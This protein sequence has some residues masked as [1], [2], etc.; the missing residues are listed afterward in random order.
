MNDGISFAKS[1]LIEIIAE[2]R[3]FPVGTAMQTAQPTFAGDA[4]QLAMSFIRQ[5]GGSAFPRAEKLVPQGFPAMLHEVAWRF[6]NPDAPGT[7]LQIGSGIFTANALPPY[8]RWSAFRPTVQN[9]VNALLAARSDG[10][11]DQPFSGLSLCYMN[12]FLPELMEQHSQLEFMERIL[13]FKVKVP[14]A[15]KRVQTAGRTTG[16]S[17]NLSIPISGTTK[18]LILVVADGT[19]RPPGSTHI[20]PAVL[21]NMTVVETKLVA[22]DVDAIIRSFDEARNIIHDAF[23]EMTMSIRDLMQPEEAV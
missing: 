5:P 11:R 6:R 20:S 3:W 21:M 15:I 17:I 19:M 8:E 10:E 18:Q 4:D 13:G 7:L 23:L 14:Q 2:L 1:P 12:G 16:T 9:G 22:P